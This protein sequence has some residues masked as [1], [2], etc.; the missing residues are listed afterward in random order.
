MP[1][2]KTNY[3]FAYE[4]LV[5]NLSPVFELSCWCCVLKVKS[6]QKSIFPGSC[7]ILW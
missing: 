6:N 1:L 3:L 5:F 2:E 4:K 7:F